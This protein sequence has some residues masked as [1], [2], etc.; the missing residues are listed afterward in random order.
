MKNWIRNTR[1]SWHIDRVVALGKDEQ[2]LVSLQTEAGMLGLPH[3][4]LHWANK[5]AALKTR[6]EKHLDAIRKLA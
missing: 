3:A 1:R 2:E 5:A 6:R 4:A